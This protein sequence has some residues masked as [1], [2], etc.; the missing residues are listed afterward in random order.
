[1]T[2]TITAIV[3]AKNEAAM[4]ANCLET[5]QWC[6]EVVVIDHHSEDA[7]VGIAERAGARVTTTAGSFAELRNEG[8]A[9]SKTEWLFYI[10]ADERVTPILAQEIKEVISTGSDA[11]YSLGRNNIL[12]GHLLNH[13]GWE[14]DRVV[15]LF[16]RAALIKWSGAIH[17][18]AEVSGSIG[19]LKQALVHFTHRSVVSSLVKSSQWT[20]IEAQLLFEAGVPPVTP[21]TLVRKTMMEAWRRLVI[22]R[23]H[24]DGMAGWVEGLTQALN[25]LLV[26]LQVWELQ[27]KP[28]IPDRYQRYEQSIADLWKKQS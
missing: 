17:E 26:Y 23:G 22:K 18:H 11:A 1:M 9:R 8:L 3:I 4:L 16:Q 15:R 14:N 5:L 19:E 21:L 7:T 27:Q 10:D 13:G 25:R 24:R 2:S 28:S 6:D 12:Y 20:P